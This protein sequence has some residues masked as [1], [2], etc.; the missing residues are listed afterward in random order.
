M[1]YR[2]MAE[3]PKEEK[4]MSD[5]LRIWKMALIA[6]VTMVTVITA[7]CTY[8]KIDSNRTATTL[9]KLGALSDAGP[10]Q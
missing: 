5:S 1:P 2:T 7:S 9:A 10:G 8:A 3:M 6:G 4:K